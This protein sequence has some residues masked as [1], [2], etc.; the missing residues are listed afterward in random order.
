M[1]ATIRTGDV[2]NMIQSQSAGCRGDTL[3]ILPANVTISICP[4][5][6]TSEIHMKPGLYE[7]YT[8]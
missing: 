1:S 4:S 6:I 2:I 5:T 7:S 8:F 3:N